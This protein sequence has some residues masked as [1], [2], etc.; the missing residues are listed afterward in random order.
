MVS[1]LQGGILCLFADILER[2]RRRDREWLLAFHLAG[3]QIV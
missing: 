2:G 3:V 1:K